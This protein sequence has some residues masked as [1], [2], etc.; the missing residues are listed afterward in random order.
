MVS[1][2]V[3]LILSAFESQVEHVVREE[4]TIAAYEMIEIYCE[5]AVARLPIIESQKYIDFYIIINLVMS[6]GLF[7]L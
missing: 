3:F 4:K 6:Y 2:V 1:F 5:L 7:T